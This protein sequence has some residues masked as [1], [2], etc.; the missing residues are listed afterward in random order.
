MITSRVII[1][2][3]TILEDGQLNLREDTIYEE[4]GA[5]LFRKHHRRPLEPDQDV[6]GETDSRLLAVIGAMWTDQVKADYLAKK[7]ARQEQQAEDTIRGRR[8]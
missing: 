3:L 1:G 2:A 5:E 6:R 4:N 8:P 7:R